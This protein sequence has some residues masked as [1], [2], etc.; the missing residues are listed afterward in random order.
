MTK[1]YTGTNYTGN[2]CRK[3]TDASGTPK[4]DPSD[5]GKNFFGESENNAYICRLDKQ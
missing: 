5:K 2:P 4:I 3:V 1:I